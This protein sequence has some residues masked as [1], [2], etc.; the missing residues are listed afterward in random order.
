MTG[1]AKKALSAGCARVVYAANT[2]ICMW[3]RDLS[4]E[5]DARS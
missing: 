2:G 5:I 3:N 1:S 4:H